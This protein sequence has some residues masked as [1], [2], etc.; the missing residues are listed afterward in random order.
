[1]LPFP[2]RPDNWE[3][4]MPY[5]NVMNLME[6][7]VLVRLQK[8]TATNKLM[9]QQYTE[10]MDITAN[11][12]FK[13]NI[14]MY[15]GQPLQLYTNNKAAWYDLKQTRTENVGK[16]IN[17]IQKFIRLFE[18]TL[19]PLTFTDLSSKLFTTLLM[20]QLW[21]FTGAEA[22]KM[23]QRNIFDITERF[24]IIKDREE[25]CR[26]NYEITEQGLPLQLQQFQASKNTSPQPKQY[27]P[28][29]SKEPYCINHRNH[30]HWTNERPMSSLGPKPVTSN[31][32]N[33]RSPQAPISNWRPYPKIDRYRRTDPTKNP[34]PYRQQTTCGNNVAKFKYETRITISTTS[35]FSNTC[36]S[37]IGQR[38]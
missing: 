6:R 21:M 15:M 16:Y 11:E 5:W 2:E 26:S 34:R 28:R 20:P 1:M 12:F 3:L 13:N 29:N 25:A 10:T 19:N 9:A 24:K 22:V 23:A 38:S 4:E 27:P 14:N 32:R 7:E 36:T 31:F 8:A 35:I 30:S 18:F 33:Y 37:N 17:K